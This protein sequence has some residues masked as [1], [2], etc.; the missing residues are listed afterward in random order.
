[1]PDVFVTTTATS[2]AAWAGV[3]H[4]I[5]AP[6]FTWT[7]VHALP[8]K[9]TVAPDSN[10]FPTIV[11]A[12]PPPADPVDGLTEATVTVAMEAPSGFLGMSG[13]EGAKENL[14]PAKKTSAP[15]SQ[16]C[17]GNFQFR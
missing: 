4:T 5:S 8:P 10:P 1:M 14:Q 7:P 9:V 16:V 6:E 11:T 3:V 17:G 12:A 2:P 15:R 13:L